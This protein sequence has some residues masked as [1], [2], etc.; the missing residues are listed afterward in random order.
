MKESGM[1]TDTKKNL[2]LQKLKDAT[3]SQENRVAL[4]T[5]QRD[6]VRNALT[7]T[8]LVDDIVKTVEW[9]NR[10]HEVSIL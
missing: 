1:K 6:D 4:L 9:V 5:L 10:E 8:A 3:I 2:V 7:G